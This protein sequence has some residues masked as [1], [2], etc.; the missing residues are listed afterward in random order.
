[1]KLACIFL[2]CCI[3]TAHIAASVS[4]GSYPK[5]CSWNGQ[6][7]SGAI[8]FL[9][10]I[11]RLVMIGLSLCVETSA[12]PEVCRNS[13][14]TILLQRIDTFRNELSICF[15]GL[16]LSPIPDRGARERLSTQCLTGT[17]QQAFLENV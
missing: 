15:D 11:S 14:V 17:C 2:S 10:E 8:Y 3:C 13:V 4:D 9:D 7:I 1:M 5:G 12:W 16:S 6:V